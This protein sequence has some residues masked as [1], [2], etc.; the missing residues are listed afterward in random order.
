MSNIAISET[1]ATTEHCLS[2]LAC[3]LCGVEVFL[4]K[5]A[6]H[7]KALR[8]VKGI[9][10]FHVYATEFWTEYLLHHAAARSFDGSSA[11]LD[12][13][14]RLA[15]KL[16][17]LT[18]TM[19]TMTGQELKPLSAPVDERMR[20]LEEW[21]LLGE[22]VDTS[23]RARSLKKLESNL[24]HELQHA[25]DTGDQMTSDTKVL[26]GGKQP[27]DN[28]SVEEKDSISLMLSSYQAIV[29]FLLKQDQY[30]GISADDLDLF[31]SQF[32]SSAFTC[33]LSF[34]PRATAGFVL[35]ELRR[36]HEIAHT[37]LSV[38]TVPDCK[39]PPFAS[40]RAL[41]NH[42]NKYHR[43]EPIR[44]PIR[45]VGH[46][47]LL[48]K[49][50]GLGVR[51]GSRSPISREESPERPGTG[52]LSASLLAY[53]KADKLAKQPGRARGHIV[54]R[55]NARG[56]RASSGGARSP[57]S[58]PLND[59][60]QIPDGNGGDASNLDEMVNVRIDSI[61]FRG[62]AI[63]GC[64]MRLG[65]GNGEGPYSQDAHEFMSFHYWNWHHA[66]SMAQC[67]VSR[68]QM[69]FSRNEG[70]QAHYE[71]RHTTLFCERCDA[72]C[73]D[74][75]ALEDE[76]RHHW[77]SNHL[78]LVE[79]W[80]CDDPRLGAKHSPL[81]LPYDSCESCR[82]ERKFNRRYDAIKHL[83]SEHFNTITDSPQ[84][85]LSRFLCT[86]VRMVRVYKAVESEETWRDRR[87]E[88]PESEVSDE[89]DYLRVDSMFYVKE[90]A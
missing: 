63:P 45:R 29:R 69:I 12:L 70:L 64:G 2:T 52:E 41:K 17:E 56:R 40:I 39:Y 24:I 54:L 68:C 21:P 78:R 87:V 30:P 5:E 10:G 73:P 86:C 22:L 48:G 53:S 37:Q 75:F 25:T 85:P 14:L 89:E 44:R 18:A 31:K 83:K 26:S 36:Q 3:L 79:K 33:R 66:D 90:L 9:H 74:G 32:Q 43:P 57:D 72:N 19:N 27:C 51:S 84:E 50:G 35:E 49:R 67:A 20:F 81:V 6:Q 23:L 47:S 71:Q 55:E 28:A 88:R 59:I 7:T 80:M 38:C 34:C 62:C 42:I 46:L 82:G 15:N 1:E 13:A 76:L 11:V 61:G 77:R 16:N 8:V 65:T 60:A 4:G 58:S